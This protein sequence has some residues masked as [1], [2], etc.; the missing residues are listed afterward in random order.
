MQQSFIGMLRATLHQLLHAVPSAGRYFASL[1]E[2]KNRYSQGSKWEWEEAELREVLEQSLI[3]VSKTHSITIFLDALDEAG[4][5]HART[6]VSYIYNV[7]DQLNYQHQTR[8]CFS[9][10][11]YPLIIT[12]EG[13]QIRVEDENGEDIDKFVAAEIRRSIVPRGRSR[14]QVGR[15]EPSLQE[16]Q[17]TISLHAE[18]VFLWVIL[19]VERS[20]KQY[21]RGISL[22]QIIEGMT[23]APAHLHDIYE[24]ILMKEDSLEYEDP[25]TRRNQ[26][27]H[28]M[29]WICLAQYPL[30]V[31]ELRFALAAD[32]SYAVESQHPLAEKRGLVDSDLQMEAMIID[33]S[34]GLVEIRIADEP[35]DMRGENYSDEYGSDE[36]G[37]D[38]N[39]GDNDEDVSFDSSE[40]SDG[41]H[42]REVHLVQLIHQ[43]VEDFLLQKG[44]SLLGQTSQAETI[45]HGHDRLCRSCGNTLTSKEV[46]PAFNN[47]ACSGF[48]SPWNER[49]RLRF[50]EEQLPFLGYAVV[51]GPSMPL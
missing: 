33:L 13:T 21:Q 37:S 49:E 7:N 20:I 14:P 4:E 31:T 1:F 10:R 15:R 40:S 36:N 3:L 11:Y 12:N 2:E 17:R 39:D 50:G 25:T 43:S 34:G 45:A 6:I 51:P 47:L 32:D 8:I 48:L 35:E 23:K 16:L 38:A 28:L 24:E 9:C 44:L 46:Q 41:E 18:G 22:S 42:S 5:D 29:Q 30:S 26:R 27:L 19:I